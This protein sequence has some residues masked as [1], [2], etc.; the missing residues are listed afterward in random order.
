[1]KR[2]IARDH[3]VLKRNLPKYD[4]VEAEDSVSE[5][6]DAPESQ[7]SIYVSDEET[8][9]REIAVSILE[10]FPEEIIKKILKSCEM[11]TLF[12][13]R[14]AN[15]QF[16]E[17]THK[18]CASKD[19]WKENGLSETGYERPTV[20]IDFTVKKFAHLA[21]ADCIH[22]IFLPL[23]ENNFL[24]LLDY[25]YADSYLESVE[26]PFESTK[27]ELE[28][29]NCILDKRYDMDACETAARCGRLEILEWLVHRGFSYDSMDMFHLAAR[30]NKVNILDWL[31][32]D[33]IKDVKI[34]GKE[35]KIT[36][37]RHGFSNYFTFLLKEAARNGNLDVLKWSRKRKIPWDESICAAAAERITTNNPKDLTSL[38][39]LK[40]LRK[41]GC[42]W[43]YK[44]C[45]NAAR[46]GNLETLKWARS[47]GCEWKPDQI[48][49]TAAFWVT[50]YNQHDNYLGDPGDKELGYRMLEYIL[51][52]GI[53]LC[54]WRDGIDMIS[55]VAFIAIQED[56]IQLLE[57]TLKRSAI[58]KHYFI[59]AVDNDNLT[60]LKW[61]YQYAFRKRED[62]RFLK[63]LERKKFV[64]YDCY[65]RALSR[66]PE[67]QEV[68][69]WL[70]KQW[71]KIYEKNPIISGF[72]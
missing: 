39:V 9:H 42:D 53:D 14:G 27:N 37:N 1:M 25:F 51:S 48:M 68:I 67:N 11:M 58:S 23:I 62:L 49:R 16:H 65:Q 10:Y 6:I 72:L 3:I 59:C 30:N 13:L 4:R 34:F 70:K 31:Y 12:S 5:Y 2:H 15:K 35:A 22:L 44:T 64:T 17:I 32:F 38:E 43:N 57:W 45:T 61:L 26:F 7:D 41:V 55:E 50:Q 29:Q 28:K 19:Y 63:D 60:I 24:S 33:K 69:D 52:E 20:K 71:T 36:G 8:G 47:Q 40:W 18:I 56:S 54:L 46:A 66:N 21:F